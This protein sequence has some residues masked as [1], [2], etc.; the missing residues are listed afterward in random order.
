MIQEFKF[1]FGAN[2]GDEFGGHLTHLSPL[3][4]AFLA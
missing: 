1:E 3:G 2:S 4:L